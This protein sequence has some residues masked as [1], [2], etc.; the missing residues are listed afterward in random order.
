MCSYLIERHV[1]VALNVFRD[2]VLGLAV[3]VHFRGRD[4]AQVFVDDG[5]EVLKNFGEW[6]HQW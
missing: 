6:L 4:V 3:G 2:A 1:R 5:Q